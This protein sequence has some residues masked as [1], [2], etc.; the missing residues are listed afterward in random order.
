MQV[1]RL[2][3]GQQSRSKLNQNQDT[4]FKGG[5][6]VLM[7]LAKPLQM[8]DADPIK[9]VI[10]LDVTTAIAPNTAIDTVERNPAQGFETFRRELS[11][12]VINCILPGVAV[13]GVAWA[14]KNSVLGDQFKDIPV[15]RIWAGQDTIDNGVAS[16]KKVSTATAEDDKISKFVEESFSRLKPNEESIK[17][18]GSD[19]EKLEAEK[20][21]KES[22][23]K[24]VKAIQEQ[25][26]A[27]KPKIE[28]DSKLLNEIHAG[29]TKLYG[30]SKSLEIT[31]LA[32]NE[33][34]GK[35]FS[36]GMKN[37]IRDTFGLALAFSNKSVT[38]Q[39]IDKFAE[40]TKKLLW[41]KSGVTMLGVGALALAMQTIN[42]RITEKMTGRKG[43]SG[44]KDLN[45]DAD[46]VNQNPRE[47][48]KLA[49]GKLLATFASASIMATMGSPTSGV[50]NFVAPTTTMNQGRSLYLLTD[51]GRVNAAS[52]KNE[53]KDTIIRD[54]LIFL[55]LYVVG[56]F[57]QKGIIEGVQKYYKKNKNID[58]NLFNEGKKLDSN[59]GIFAK[60][61]HWVQT[62]SVKSFEEVEGTVAKGANNKL[63]KNV[64]IASTVAS[65]SYSLG[66]LGVIAPI[67]IA[68]MT[69]KNRE[70]QLAE[71]QKRAAAKNNSS[72]A[73]SAT[74]AATVAASAQG[75]ARAR[76]NAFEP[77]KQ[78][79]AKAPR[80]Y[81]SQQQG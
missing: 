16:W 40:K 23:E 19:K 2:N 32:L 1:S 33:K 36:T 34:G 12:L 76:K 50:L 74:A 58:L 10:F 67:M 7:S 28:I 80:L 9:G 68:K 70:R 81:T 54:A 59:A 14:L 17:L 25:R 77:I 69:N 8:L 26:K 13:V 48:K 39:N 49:I 31:R 62:K 46:A 47:K 72:V 71:A 38:P 79:A 20:A 78:S 44:Y 65:L 29:M 22:L 15:H 64:L 30:D 55:N 3:N 43:Y 18:K 53:L 57:V 56:N 60:V 4:K 6:D 51:M 5:A 73:S 45:S 35:T 41:V 63:R 61:K 75:V 27:N 52:D 37:Y 42:R 11:G 21:A 24:L 66:A